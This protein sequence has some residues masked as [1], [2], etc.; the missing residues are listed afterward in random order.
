MI[1][2]PTKRAMELEDEME[3]IKKSLTSEKERDVAEIKKK[4]ED[5]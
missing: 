3:K 5:G 1:E 4:H 2:T